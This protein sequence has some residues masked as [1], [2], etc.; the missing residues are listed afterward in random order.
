MCYT[1]KSNFIFSHID[2]LPLTVVLRALSVCELM[3]VAYPHK[4]E[5]GK[6]V[7]KCVTC[8]GRW[9]LVQGLFSVEYSE[10]PIPIP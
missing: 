2:Y 1:R 4:T 9:I 3:L 7:L 6:K 5:Q 10:V 8:E